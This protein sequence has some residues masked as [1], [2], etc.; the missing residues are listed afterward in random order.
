MT[1]GWSIWFWSLGLILGLRPGSGSFAEARPV[2]SPG[3]SL[4]LLM[5]FPIGKSVARWDQRT[6]TL[7][8]ELLMPVT[9]SAYLRQ[10]G[11]AAALNQLQLWA[12]MSTVAV[13]CV[14]VTGNDGPPLATI[15]D[16]LVISGLSQI[17]LF[18]VAVWWTR[19]QSCLLGLL[20]GLVAIFEPI[21]LIGML[22]GGLPA[23]WRVCN[24]VRGRP[25][26]PVRPAVDA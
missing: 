14:L 5:F 17:W 24:V 11:G 15:L 7:A 9:R 16:L 10:L 3:D 6:P 20:V 21:V 26:C 12:A 1:T 25:V 19:C 22:W 2:K 23:E 13:A 18:G 4:D 8:R